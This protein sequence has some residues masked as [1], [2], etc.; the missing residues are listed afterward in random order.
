M[1]W[2]V[3]AIWA[4]MPLTVGDLLS[5]ALDGRSGPVRLTTVVMAWALWAAGLLATLVTLPPA[6]T[7]LRILA[8]L[9]LAAAIAAA[10]DTAPSAIGWVGLGSAALVAVVTLSAEVGGD[11]ID[12]ASYGDERRF[13][14]RP[15]GALLL[16]PL[17]LVWLVVTV[18][19]IAGALLLAARQWLP[20]AASLLGGVAG[21][22]WGARVLNRLSQRCVVFVP[23]G[24]TLVDHL[25][26]AEPVLFRR[27]DVHRIGPA[28]VDTAAHDLSGAAPGLILQVDVDPA[29]TI[30]PRVGRS[31]PSEP[32]EAH[33]VLIA[34]SRP[35]ALLDHAASTDL[36]VQRG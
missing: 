17:Q 8:P 23:A 11:F 5:A 25:T 7:V 28:P 14:L 29:V 36:A 22:W 34:P 33:D 13:G 31:R 9:P 2:L 6:L 26:L 15:P 20:G 21:I 4:T 16:G 35:G 1:T 30:T 32:V 3:R 24:M 27:R 19:P 12:G 10:G 18:P